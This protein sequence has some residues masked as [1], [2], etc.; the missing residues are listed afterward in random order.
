MQKEVLNVE[1]VTIC[2]A[3]DSGDGM[4]LTGTQF[5]N[6]AALA[7]NDL[8]SFPDFPAEIRAPAGTRAGVSGFQLQFSSVSI[9]TP[10]DEADV[11]V[12]MNPA[13]LVASLI[14]IKRGGTIIVNTDKFGDRDLAKADLDSNPL[15]DGTLDGYEVMEVPLGTLVKTAVEDL[16][17]KTK[18]VDRCKNFFALGMA[19]WMFERDM[20]FTVNWIEGKFKTPYKEAN[21]R[22]LHAGN[23]YAETVE[24]FQ[25]SY[26]VPAAKLAPGI[27]RNIN[28]TQAM[29]MGLTAGATLAKRQLFYGTYPITPATD[30]LHQLAK[31]KHYNVTTFQAEDEIAAVCSAIGAAWAGAIGV[32]GTSG[33]GLAL[34]GEGI[35]LAIMIE[36]PLIV[37][38]VQRGGPSTGL[39]TKTEQSD[40]TMAYYGRNGEA[41]MAIISA[42]T[43]SD[44]FEV[45]IEAVRIALEHMTPV[46][47]LFDG[48]LA[49]GSEPWKLPEVDDL[50]PIGN[51]AVTENN[52]PGGTFLPYVRDEKTLAR[53][54]AIPGTPGLEHRVGGLEKEAL[55]GN[56]SYDPQNHE[57]MCKV[58]A[59]KVARIAD[60]IPEQEVFGSEEGLLVLAWGSTYGAIRQAV[61]RANQ[62]G[63]KVAHAH[64][65][66][67]NPFPKNLEALCKGYEKILIP[68]MNLGQLSKRIR[69]EYYIDSTELHKVQGQPFKVSEITSAID[70]LL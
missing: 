17:L 9:Y 3:G 32:T 34:K 47:V 67:L 21:L 57:E 28:G 65:R 7:G 60:F 31:F 62:E 37:L 59:E 5:T 16:G 52:N 43:P 66:H 6:T 70:N 22:A 10:G 51:H 26:E 45:G 44:C 33:P 38:D 25:R 55:T 18:E 63:K 23:A 49:N 30:T 68:E 12:A 56:V 29:A 19:Y 42:S 1:S 61:I 64:I 39:P 40:L 35:G 53:Q 46:M 54:W 11:L 15:E 24:V 41:P 69:S 36:L 14:K 13:A 48:Y 4:Q 20:S 58:R 8:A 27:Y 50:K 2:F